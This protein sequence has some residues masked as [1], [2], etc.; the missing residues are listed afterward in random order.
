MET[1]ISRSRWDF[2][3]EILDF[4]R[5]NKDVVRTRIERHIVLTSQDAKKHF[6]LLQDEGYMT[7]HKEDYGARK[8]YVCNATEKG[9]V[10]RDKIG[11]VYD[12]FGG[13]RPKW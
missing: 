10:L 2:L 9:L 13:K 3:Y 12:L 7:I 1:N 6:D 5:S 4:L 11:H 8:L